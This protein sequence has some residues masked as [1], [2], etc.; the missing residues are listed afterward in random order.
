MSRIALWTI[1]LAGCGGITPY[2]TP[3]DC[4]SADTGC[5]AETT[6]LPPGA[7]AED[8]T[9]GVDNDLDGLVDCLDDSCDEECDA[10]ND[11]HLSE[12]MG[13]NDCDD[14]NPAAYPG[15]QEVCDDVDN[16]CDGYIDDDDDDVNLSD[17]PTWYLDSDGDGYGNDNAFKTACAPPPDMVAEG[18]DCDDVDASISPAEPDVS[19]D[20]ID[21]DCNEATPD[22]PDNDGDGTGVCSDCDDNDPNRAPNLEE[23]C[24][25]GH[26]SNCDGLD[27]SDWSDD[28]ESGSLD[29]VWSTSGNQLWS[30]GAT[31]VH[32]GSFAAMSGNI[33][34][35]QTSSL[36]V[37]L[38]F[39]STGTIS[40]WHTEST[41]GSYDYLEFYIDGALQNRW[42][43]ITGWTQASF[44]VTKGTHTMQWR[45]VKDSSVNSGADTVWID[46]VEA[47]N[48][49]P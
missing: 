29:A 14:T 2:V 5:A 37:T 44:A 6:T 45:Y 9:D 26:D 35:N 42:S 7:A 47:T 4:D 12:E 32:E 11:G 18:G 40:F 46:M 43:G 49:M 1:F 17:A 25:D 27:C 15:A 39:S 22:D 33:N 30:V 23:I 36:E 31:N 21:N 19:C 41:E 8:C 16:D 28:F 48:G 34:H 20:G 13:G 3:D 38:T 10:D 24:G